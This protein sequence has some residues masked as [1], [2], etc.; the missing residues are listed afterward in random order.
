MTTIVG[1]YFDKKSD[2]ESSKPQLEKNGSKSS[3]V[4][5]GFAPKVVKP[6]RKDTAGRETEL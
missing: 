5:G 2:S 3:R 1:A 6:K 4:G